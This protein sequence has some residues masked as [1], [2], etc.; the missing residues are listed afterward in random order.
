MPEVAP[1]PKTPLVR[2]K[3]WLL[4]KR[5]EEVQ[6]PEVRARSNTPGGR[7]CA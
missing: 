7:W 3:R 1:A 2:L 5:I 4:K 6:G